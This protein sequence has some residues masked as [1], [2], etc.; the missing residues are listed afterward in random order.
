[1]SGV[2]LGNQRYASRT[3]SGI[4]IHLSCETSCATSSFANILNRGSG[5][6]GFKVPGSSGGGSGSG[7]SAWML[8][9]DVGISSCLRNTARVPFEEGMVRPKLESSIY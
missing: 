9:H 8:Y 5:D 3:S 6:I 1:M 7:R 2:G 4:L